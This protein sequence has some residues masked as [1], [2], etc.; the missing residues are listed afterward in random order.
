MSTVIELS[1]AELTELCRYTA[2]DD[3]SAAATEAIR[4]YIRY[5]KRERL[6]ELSDQVEMDQSWRELGDASGR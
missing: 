4:E 5:C 2:Q 6:I 3:P 1:D